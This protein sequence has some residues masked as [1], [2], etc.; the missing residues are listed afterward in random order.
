[1]VCSD[2]EKKLSKVIV[3]D[4]WKAG[5]RN[6][7]GG[8]D[9]GRETSARNSLLQVRGASQRFAPKVKACQI[10]RS[11]V[12]QDANY[13]QDCAFHKGICAMCGVRVSDLR[14][15]KRDPRS[16]LNQRKMKGPTVA[17]AGGSQ[18]ARRDD[19]AADD[20]ADADARAGEKRAAGPALPP[21]AKR[22]AAAAKAAAAPA[23]A[24]T[25]EAVAS[26][27]AM[28]AVASAM[29][30]NCGG[31]GGHAP[32]PPPGAPP[33][34]TPAWMGLQPR[35]PPGPP[36]GAADAY[37]GWASVRDESSGQTYYVHVQSGRTT[38]Q[39]PPPA[40]DASAPSAQTAADAADDDAADAPSEDAALAG[41]ASATDEATGKAYYFHRE[42]G[43]TS[44]EWPPV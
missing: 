3:P 8:A 37:E 42:S 19:D 28:Q 18:P 33:A 16:E 26:A 36:P 5:A 14:F 30:R 21:G 31:G 12:S 41:W 4:K 13:C 22:R 38:W 25:E 44:W 10:C 35:P 39:W 6:T 9:G 1:M 29:E 34:A 23:P 32:R 2:C 27:A 17:P 20:D 11:K 15:D 40:E 24:P 43:R 7:T